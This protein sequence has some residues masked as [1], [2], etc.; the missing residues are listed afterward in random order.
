MLKICPKCRRT[1]SGGTICLSCSPE[2]ALLDVALPEVRKAHL[3]SDRDLRTTIRTYYGARSA[4]LLLFQGILLGLLVFALLLR[5]AAVSSGTERLLL[6]LAAAGSGV[7][8][9]LICLFG[10]TRLVHR[11]SKSCHRKPISPKDIPVIRRN[12]KLA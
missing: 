2:V 10:G 5:K 12:N 7:G 4:M 6:M 11:F 8:L 3:K 9:P 1:F